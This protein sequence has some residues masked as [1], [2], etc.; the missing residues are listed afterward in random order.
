VIVWRIRLHETFPT[1]VVEWAIGVMLCGWGA[2][3]TLFPDVMQNVLFSVMVTWIPQAVWA[4]IFL[5]TGL[6]RL[7]MLA[8]NGAWRATPWFR[9][10]L[11]FVSLLLWGTVSLGLALS[12]PATGLAVYPVLCAL[13]GWNIYRAAGD[14][15]QTVTSASGAA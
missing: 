9:A 4:L 7:A 14:A 11:S 1:R 5:W 6:T 13:E 15:R 10:A 2:I 3:L 8:I 12:T